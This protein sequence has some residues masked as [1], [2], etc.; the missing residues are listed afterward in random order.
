M[1]N[2]KLEALLAHSPAGERARGAYPYR[3]RVSRKARLSQAGRD[4]NTCIVQNRIL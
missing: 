2:V 3:L 4:N 1:L